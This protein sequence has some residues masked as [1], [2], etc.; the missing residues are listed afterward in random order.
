KVRFIKLDVKACIKLFE[1][2]IPKFKEKAEKA[3]HDAMGENQPSERLKINHP[4][5][6]KSTGSNTVLNNTELNNTEYTPLTPQKRKNGQQEPK[7]ENEERPKEKGGNPINQFIK[8]NFDKD[9]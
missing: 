9:I 6:R 5:G 4:N 7:Q 2:V 1:E 3:R 8:D